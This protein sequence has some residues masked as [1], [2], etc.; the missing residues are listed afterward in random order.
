[1]KSSWTHFII[2]IFVVVNTVLT[3]F[4]MPIIGQDMINAVVVVIGGLYTV[5][6]FFKNLYLTKKG[7]SQHKALVAQGLAK[8]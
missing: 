2:G 5:F 6:L 7:K 4:H 8:K 1:M 3:V